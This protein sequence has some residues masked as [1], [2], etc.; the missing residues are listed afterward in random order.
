[1][2]KYCYSLNPNIRYEIG[3]EEG[4]RPIDSD[5]LDR[6]VTHIKLRL[7]PNIYSNIVYLVI[8]CG[9]KLLVQSNIGNYVAEKLERMLLVCKKHNLIAKEHNGDWISQDIVREKERAGLSCINIA[10]EFGEIES[11]IIIDTFKQNYN[12]FETFFTICHESNT[13][14]KWV[15]SDFNPQLHKEKLI[16]ICGHYNFTN[17]LFI[18]LKDKYPDLDHAICKAIR[19]RLME[20]TGMYT[21]RDTCIICENKLTNQVLSHDAETSICYSF[22]NTV[23]PSHFIPYNIYVCDTCKCVQN[24]YLCNLTE[25]YKVNH[26]DSFGQVKH[27]MHTFFAKFITSNSNITGTIEIGACHDYLSRLILH[28][29]KI[30]ITI[31]DPSFSGNPDQ[32]HII[33]NYIEDCDLSNIDSNTIIMSS[34]FEHFYKPCEIINKIKNASNIDYIYI[35]HPNLDFALENNVHINLT[36]EHTFYINN[37]FINTLFNKYQFKLTRMEYFE[38]HTICYEFTR[39]NNIVTTTPFINEVEIFYQ[40]IKSIKH[41]ISTLNDIIEQHIDYSFYMWPASMHL[42]PLFI[43]GFNYSKLTA[44]LDNSPNKIGKIFYGYNLRCQDFYEVIKE[45][46][47][48]TIL[49]LGGASNYKKELDLSTFKG[50]VIN[51]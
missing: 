14:K 41:T 40:Y 46:S 49:F 28:T 5:E 11:S 51:I 13:W 39:N 34:V 33:N 29:R 20:L 32:L 2:I 22:F 25:L 6:F 12:D 36:A 19:Y 16:K 30:P 4:I 8:Q 37:S 17:P 24:K 26:I 48:S 50:L 35:N 7:E 18:Q 44:L 3:T 38:N 42:I 23:Q 21:I 45:S 47:S 15:S 27:N 10:P 1:M 43:H 31:I 9:T